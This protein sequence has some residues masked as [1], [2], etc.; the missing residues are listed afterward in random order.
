MFLSPIH[1]AVSQ[2]T[3]QNTQTF[4]VPVTHPPSRQSI[5]SS[6]YPDLLCSC[7][8]STQPSVNQLI[9]IPRAS[10]SLSS[11]HPAVSQS[12]HQNTQSFGVPVTHPPSR[13]SIN[14]SKY[15]ELRCSCHPSTQPSLT[16][17]I[18]IPRPS[19]FLS[20]IHPA[21][22]QST[23]QNTQ[24][25]GVPVTHPPSRHSLNPS[26]IQQT[27]Q[28]LVLLIIM[29]SMAIYY[30][31]NYKQE[32]VIYIYIMCVRACVRACECVRA[33]ARARACVCICVCVCA[34]VCA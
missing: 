17:P 12:T 8:P 15:P 32:C 6:K 19:V 33:C 10:V 9:K 21:V 5:N 31:S 14:P 26:I 24:S 20:P 28:L 25:F 13:Q 1:P 34:C 23:H 30:E 29:R 18:K 7:H 16:Q 2:S 4:Y 27:N 3:H 22:S 11:I